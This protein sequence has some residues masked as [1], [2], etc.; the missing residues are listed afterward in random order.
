MSREGNHKKR[1][2]ME[3]EEG[4]GNIGVGRRVRNTWKSGERVE[5]RRRGGHGAVQLRVGKKG[6]GE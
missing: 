3:W 5:G 4:L 2:G 1:V 6:E